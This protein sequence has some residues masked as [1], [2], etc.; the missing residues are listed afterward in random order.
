MKHLLLIF[1]L[2]NT[3]VLNAQNNKPTPTLHIKKAQQKIQL[4]GIL[5]ESDWTNAEKAAEFYQNYP[6]DTSYSIT[7]TEVWMTYDEHFIYVGAQC[8][9]DMGCNYVIQSLKRDFSY[10]LSDAFA[11]YFDPFNDQTNGFSFAVNPLG[12]QREG[13]LENGGSNGVTTSW[14]NRWFSK[15]TCNKN[16]YVVEMAIPFKTLRYNSDIKEWG[17]NFSRNELQ[18]NENSAW[19]AVPRNFNIATM[20]FNGKLI[21]DAPPK[22][23][24]MNLS[25]IP[26]GIAGTNIDYQ[27]DTSYYK[28]NTG[29]DAKVAVTSSLNLDLTINPDFSQVEVD[30]QPVNLTRFSI[31]LPEKRQFFIENNDLFARFGFSM[32]RPFFSRQIGIYNGQHVPILFGARLSGKVNKNWRIGVMNM[33]TAE[34]TFYYPNDTILLAPQNYTV[35]A[36]QRQVFKRSNIAA[37]FVNRQKIDG[38]GIDHG[39]YNRIVGLDYNIASADNKWQGKLYYHQS[40]TPGINNN[41]RS[42]TNASWLM[43]STQKWFVM[44]NHEY[45]GKNYNAEV[46]FVPRN[47]M[48]NPKTDA[49]ETLS[50]WRLE[51]MIQYKIY[52]KSSIINYHGPALYYD[53]YTDSI[54]KP[55]D[56]FIMPHY[57]VFFINSSSFELHYHEWYT[58]LLYDTDITFSGN[59]PIPAGEYRYRGGVLKYTSNQRK[60]LNGNINIAYNT[61]YFGDKFSINGG[62]NY[63]VQ[64]WGIFT[65]TFSNDRIRQPQ[66]YASANIT[67]IG[68]KIELSFT[69]SLFLS[70]LIQYNTQIDNLNVNARLQWR[71]K[72]MSDLYIVYTDNYDPNLAIKNRALVV[73]FIYWL[74]V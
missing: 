52:P 43:Y 2:L 46:G 65:M 71:F 74:S 11:V 8:Y 13:L 54:Y 39:N 12:V 23:A 63:R 22:K 17:I 37:I 1:L 61:Y 4:D 68:P 73:K 67:R 14:D 5:D 25:I 56:A 40:L 33:Q 34:K 31:Q 15:V 29:L 48:F 62:L 44:W 72:P 38:N 27:N 10:P 36:V 28:L 51:P 42:A 24:G 69:K 45:V 7:K 20:A 41:Y 58:R 32:I 3:F 64:P 9:D 70:T 6:A 47:R 55:T 21:W 49:Y 57:K 50:Y 53:L 66:P 18:R 26:Y 59:T 60:K 19:A 16:G 30:D 35:A